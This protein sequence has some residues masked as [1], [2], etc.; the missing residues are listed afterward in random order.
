MFGYVIIDKPN[1]LIKDYQTY[2]SYYCGLCKSIG[3]RNGQLM[4]LTVNYDIVLLA[5]LAYNYKKIEP[6]FKQ[7][8][9]PVHWLKKIEYVDNNEI[10]EKICDVNAILGYY[11]VHDDVVD[12]GKSRGLRTLI[13]PIYKK[14]AKRLPNFDKTVKLGYENLRQA[15]KEE[16]SAEKLS[17]IFGRLLMSAGDAVVDNCDNLLRELL[18]YVGKWIYIVDAVDD[19]KKDFEKQNFNPFLRNVKTLD[20]KF[21][22]ENENIVRPML[23]QCIDKIIEVYNKMEITISEGALS[24]IIYLGLKQRTE[25]IIEKRGKKCQ[26]IRL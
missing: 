8:R 18:F 19:M 12:E 14:S 24:N 5:L 11:K 9:C 16:A 22:D 21:Y 26:E 3:K 17:D 7:G 20:D 10:N 6:E 13:K 23:Y 4:R 2:R 1:I 25:R 15:E